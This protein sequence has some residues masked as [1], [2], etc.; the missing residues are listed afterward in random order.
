MEKDIE[1][2]A[3]GEV[4]SMKQGYTVLGEIVLL[5][6]GWCSCRSECEKTRL[7]RNQSSLTR[8]DNPLVTF[9]GHRGGGW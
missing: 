4:K 6:E 3:R 9:P 7:L 2:L 8:K 1:N 5:V